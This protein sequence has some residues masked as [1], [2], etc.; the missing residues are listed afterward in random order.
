MEHNWKALYILYRDLVRRY[1]SLHDNPAVGMQVL[2]HA[3]NS[4][5]AYHD[6]IKNSF[7]LDGFVREDWDRIEQFRDEEVYEKLGFQGVH[8]H[9]PAESP[10]QTAI[11]IMRRNLELQQDA[12]GEQ[13]L[14]FRGQ[15]CHIWDVT[16]SIFRGVS[17]ESDF[18]LKLENIRCVV[19][20]LQEVGLGSNELEALAIA[21]HYSRELDIRTW[22]VD[23]TASPFVALFFATHDGVTGDIG[24]VNYISRKEWK[25]FSGEDDSLTGTLRFVSPQGIPRIVNQRGF[26]LE[27]PHPEVYRQLVPFTLFF[28]QRDRELFEDD[29]LT[30][31]VTSAHI[32]PQ[33]DPILDQLPKPNRSVPAPP[34]QWE[35]PWSISKAP[36]SSTYISIVKASVGTIADSQVALVTDICRLHGEIIA[37]GFGIRDII[38]HLHHLV[39]VSQY[40]LRF[41]VDDLQWFLDFNYFQHLHTEDQRQRFAKCI[42]NAVPMWKETA[43]L[44][45]S[46]PH[47]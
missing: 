23:V 15:R 39:R 9:N 25:R 45:A 35:P 47:H 5:K 24:V 31:P 30:P 37:Q 41:G 18:Q 1:R 13:R 19:R 12:Q 36:E 44:L 28:R 11:Q 29:T 14:F 22:L 7:G 3:L 34:L 8:A 10:Y 43:A 17:S 27:C 38:G 40:A 46:R 33:N 20:A 6:V 16:P 26:F 2:R 21:Q 4:Y 42:T 32:Y